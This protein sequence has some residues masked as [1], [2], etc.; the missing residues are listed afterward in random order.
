MANELSV[1]ISLEEKA[2]LAALT[3]LTRN[4][5][6]VEKTSVKSFG[7]MDAAYGSF[8]G[9][10]ASAAVS[11]AFSKLSGA[12]GTFISES[13]EVAQSTERITTQ[14]ETLTGS[15][16]TAE[17][18]M[19][20]L[21]DFTSKTPFRLEGVAEAANQLLAFGFSADTIKSRI[22]DIGDVAAGSNS[23]L[24]E[25]ALIYGQV[26]AAGKLT[27]ERLL[28]LQERA[29]PIGPALAKTLGVAESSVKKLV[30]EG[31]VGFDEF[32]SAFESLSAKGG[33]FEGAVQKQA[34]TLG[35]ALSTL[36][37]NIALTQ[38]KFGD[39]FGPAL[40][41][42]AQDA[43]NAI[44]EFILKNN[45]MNDILGNG[46][47]MAINIAKTAINGLISAFNFIPTAAD[48]IIIAIQA[49]IEGIANLSAS[50]LEAKAK[51]SEFFGG[52]G[53]EARAAAAEMRA[54]AQ[55][56]AAIGEQAALAIEER[57][58]R[59]DALQQKLSEIA[60]RAS[61]KTIERVQKENEAEVAAFTKKEES[62]KKVKDKVAEENK[63]RSEN[64][65]KNEQRAITDLAIYEK[66]VGKQRAENLKS[67]LGTISTLRQSDNKAAF[68][69]GKAAAISTA[70]VDGIVAVQKALASAP[71]PFNFALAGLVGAATAINISKI[72]SAK[73]PS[74]ATGGIMGSGGALVQGDN[75]T[76]NVA[77]GEM[78]LNAREQ[79]N[80]FDVAVKGKGDND[81]GAAIESL[82][83][84]PI[85]VQ[86]GTREI[87]R[88]VRDAK[89]EG[90]AI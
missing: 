39:A 44:N 90:F 71:V 18:V 2:A 50:A 7:K 74:F 20:D 26:A 72:A 30:S 23:D 34:E 31:R 53:E 78:L 21:V 59:E 54:F 56:Q 4:I 65:K 51:V 81:M 55:E 33:L 37:D 87:A 62:L 68:A 35:G 77:K 75:M 58:Q 29:I 6:K 66:M 27:G 41:S 3:K 36:N 49:T 5:E 70:T 12:L 24:Q 67:T 8:V 16:E 69:I 86:I 61:E 25:V 57:A 84:Q 32:A 88:A 40:T 47:V 83:N 9:N 76:A 1:E 28:Q 85:V 14:L 79:K 13:F 22:E 60:D 15:T 46:T 45:E 63:K 80:L 17:A 38:K 89:L 10:L 42:L 64:S 82:A 52:S 11:A 19:R 43:S 73:P 48:Y